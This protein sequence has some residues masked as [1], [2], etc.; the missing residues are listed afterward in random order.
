[1][2]V[3]EGGRGH[4][5]SGLFDPGP[6]NIQFNYVMLLVSIG[7]GITAVVAVVL[8]YIGRGKRGGWIDSH[9]S[10]QITT[11]WLGLVYL[12][13]ATLLMVIGIGFLLYLLVV[14]W[15]VAR[16]VKGLRHVAR[17][18]PIENPSTWLW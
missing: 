1:M 17:H 11:F 18:E 13:I 9:Y 14:A 4:G 16:C 15:L 7:I 6:N 10:Y 8:A 12:V 3:P 2:S 5:E